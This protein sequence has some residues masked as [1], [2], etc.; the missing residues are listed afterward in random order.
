MWTERK[1]I[2][3]RKFQNIKNFKCE[4]F[5]HLQE[6]KTTS[7]YPRKKLLILQ[8]S[9]LSQSETNFT[10]QLHIFFK[11]EIFLQTWWDNGA[12]FWQEHCLQT[13]ICKDASHS[14]NLKLKHS[15]QHFMNSNVAR[16]YGANETVN[17]Q[18]L[19]N[20]SF[21]KIVPIKKN[22]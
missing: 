14:T 13:G 19:E 12:L 22:P 10:L 8:N 11:I 17:R 9:S 6:D 3:P 18:K 5:S 7:S 1:G 16:A 4:V 21:H 2:L 15:F 20:K